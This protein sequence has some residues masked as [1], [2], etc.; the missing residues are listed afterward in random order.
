MNNLRGKKLLILGGVQLACS[1]IKLAQQNGI[2]TIVVDY[3]EDSPAKRIADK[4]YLVSTTDVDGIVE[5]C[6][7]EEPVRKELEYKIKEQEQLMPR[8]DKLFDTEKE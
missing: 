6:K 4:S 3:N 1:V 8:Y 2:Y 7:E 5:L